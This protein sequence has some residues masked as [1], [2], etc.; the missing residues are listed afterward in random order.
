MRKGLDEVS[1]LT[2]LQ[3]ALEKLR[4][5]HTDLTPEAPVLIGVSGGRDSVVLLCAMVSLGWKGLVVGHLNHALRGRESGQDAAFVKRLT[6]RLG[7]R[8]E[9]RKVEVQRVAAQRKISLELAAREVREKFF[10]SLASMVETRFLFLAHHA[11]D[12]AETILG[13]LCR[14]TALRGMRG[15]NLSAETG[16][17][18]VKLRP[19]LNVTRVEIDAYVEE[20]K[21][22]YR[23]DGSNALGSF[24]RNRLRNEVLPLLNEVLDRDVSTMLVRAGAAAS[25]DDEFLHGQAMEFAEEE[26][27]LLA[28][29][30][31]K[32]TTR[33]Q[34]LHGALLSRV[35]DIWLRHIDQARGIG[36]HELESA[37]S[38]IKPDGPAK[39]N[40]PG[41]RWLRRKAKRLFVEHL[42]D[43]P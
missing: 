10:E 41:D 3:S 18:L 23:E 35:I 43:Q 11:D 13:N 38:M 25:R 12:Q 5:Q 1:L 32:I 29:G 28:D 36:N 39:I 14:G 17:G 15:I 37:M 34:K 8:C 21:L 33:L 30:G 40:L 16:R 4:A 24:R 6:T 22:I 20:N 9:T 42:I 26:G 27:L 31:L 2:E 19:L 7:M